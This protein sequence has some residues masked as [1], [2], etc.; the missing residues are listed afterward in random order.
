M[1]VS[2]FLVSADPSQE[3]K[4]AI[5]DKELAEMVRTQAIIWIP[6]ILTVTVIASVCAL[7][8]MDKDKQKDTMLYA[9]FLSNVKEHAA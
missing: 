2:V 9:K 4:V 8:G 3:K 5:T 1:S 7:M 6:I